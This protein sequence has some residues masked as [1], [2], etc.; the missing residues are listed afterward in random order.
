M[1]TEKISDKAQKVI[2]DYMFLKVNGKTINT[3]YF[4]NP[5]SRK[6]LRAMVGK[7]TPEEIIMESKIWEKIKGVNFDQMS[8]KEIKD[9]L[10]NRGIGIDCSGFIVHVLDALS[11]ER[12]GKHV[13]S[14]LKP[15]VYRKII[16]PLMYRLRPVENLGAEIITNEKNSVPVEIKDVMPGDVIRSKA[17]QTNGH[18][19]MLV[20]E[21]LRDDSTNQVV[22]IKYTHSS[23]YYGDKMGVK[24]GEIRIK[25]IT[26]P[27]WDQEWTEKDEHGVNHTYEGFM[28]NVED[29]GLRRL[30]CFK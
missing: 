4:I 12:N 8:E 11:M 25:D 6:D 14:F 27:L 1:K 26:K 13:W 9:F 23:P 15:T 2:N 24:T 7:G 29:N 28:V 16:G 3:P 17:K 5:R 21:V 30:K 10:I 22:A 18:H 19:I 20:T